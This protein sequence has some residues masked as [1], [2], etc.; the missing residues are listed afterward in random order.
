MNIFVKKKVFIYLIDGNGILM[1]ETFFEIGFFIDPR[2]DLMQSGHGFFSLPE[3]FPT[4]HIGRQRAEKFVYF[5]LQQHHIVLFD[6]H[7]KTSYSE[8]PMLI[9]I[10]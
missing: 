9:N 1:I 8:K 6:A 4:F 3:F 10:K 2:I 5:A 7:K